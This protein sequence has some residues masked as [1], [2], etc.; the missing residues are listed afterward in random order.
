MGR[1]AKPGEGETELD[2]FVEVDPGKGS[3]N[4]PV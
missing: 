2:F 1:P 4:F 3:Y